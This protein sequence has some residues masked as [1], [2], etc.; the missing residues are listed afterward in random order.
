M[1]LFP[2][3][4]NQQLHISPSIDDWGLL[5]DHDIRVVIDLDDDVD[6]NVPTI[7]DQLLYMYFPFDDVPRLPDLR[8]LHAVARLGADLIQQGY[9]L[10]AHCGMGHNASVVYAVSDRLAQAEGE[11]RPFLPSPPLR[12]LYPHPVDG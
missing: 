10:L 7:P 3:D 1:E 4:A 5:A 8:K 2:I 12:Y 9:R 11:W 6:T